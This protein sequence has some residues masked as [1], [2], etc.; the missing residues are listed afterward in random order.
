MMSSKRAVLRRE[1]SRSKVNS[2]PMK[3]IK[4]HSLRRH[5]AVV[6]GYVLYSAGVERNFSAS[7]QA[8]PFSLRLAS[9]LCFS[10]SFSSF[11]LSATFFMM[12]NGPPPEARPA[13]SPSMRL[14]SDAC[15]FCS[16]AECPV[17][18]HDTPSVELSHATHL[19]L[20]SVLYSLSLLWRNDLGCSN[21]KERC[22]SSRSTFVRPSTPSISGP[23]LLTSSLGT[24]SLGP[25]A[26]S[27]ALRLGWRRLC[28]LES[29]RH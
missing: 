7:I 21:G 20:C 14:V 12:V 8:L 24:S 22:I 19:L 25:V 17:S 28:W 3:I 10:F 26:P 29:L 1:E 13:I 6:T 4:H 23:C 5:V 18:S 9:F 27:L 15:C 11:T 16:R 2:N